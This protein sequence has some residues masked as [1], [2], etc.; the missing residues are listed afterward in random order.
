MQTK[1]TGAYAPALK[2]ITN[3]LVIKPQLLQEL[4]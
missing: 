4:H 3:E 1:K 2:L